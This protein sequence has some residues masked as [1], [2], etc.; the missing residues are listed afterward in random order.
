MERSRPQ[1]RLSLSDRLD[2]PQSQPYFI[3]DTPITV[4]DLRE[5]LRHPDPRERSLW[6]ARIMREARYADVWR[7]LSLND[8]LER[9]DMIRRH[10][11]RRRRFWDFLIQGWRDDGLI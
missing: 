11:G 2:V 7:F 9:Y 5:R 8:V 6:M 10:L 1:E 4:A 3:W